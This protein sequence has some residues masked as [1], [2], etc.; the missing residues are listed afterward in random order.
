M[1][2]ILVNQTFSDFLIHLAATSQ[3]SY[4][5]LAII[6]LHQI[7]ERILYLIGDINIILHVTDT[8]L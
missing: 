8:Q 2:V 1:N 6:Y 4:D 5:V 3:S 7:T